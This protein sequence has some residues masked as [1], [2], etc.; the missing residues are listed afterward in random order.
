MADVMRGGINAGMITNTNVSYTKPTNGQVLKYDSATDEW[1]PGADST[2]TNATQLQGVDIC[3]TTPT[4]GQVLTYDL[5][6][7]EWCPADSGGGGKIVQVVTEKL[8]FG[9]AFPDE[10]WRATG[11]YASITPTSATNEIVIF[12][13][14]PS[15]ASSQYCIGQYDW[16]RTTSAMSSGDTLSGGT[17]IFVTDYGDSN[18][19]YVDWRFNGGSGQAQPTVNV[20][21]ID[22]TYDSTAEQFYNVVGR[23][24]N[25]G[26][27][28]VRGI[29]F[30]III[31]EIDRS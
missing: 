11:G 7:T 9:Y 31:M 2:D 19:K 27:W 8:D 17:A 3:T 1:K 13:A 5:A 21:V 14:I 22:T 28:A 26:V 16:Y 23:E 15:E 24:Y 18:G 12:S 25:G 30:S 4:D 10:T 20:D 6:S 29:P